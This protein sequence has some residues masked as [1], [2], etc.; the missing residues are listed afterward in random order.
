MFMRTKSKQEACFV[1]AG[2]LILL[3][4]HDQHPINIANTL[5]SI[6]TNF[7]SVAQIL[8]KSKKHMELSW[9]QLMCRPLNNFIAYFSA[10][11][12]ASLIKKRPDL[13]S[14]WRTDFDAFLNVMHCL[15]GCN[16]HLM[17]EEKLNGHFV[18]C[19]SSACCLTRT[20]KHL[21]T[22]H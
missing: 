22:W 21:S 20:N 16:E 13:T 2:N 19:F 6:S 15:P 7:L 8:T 18:L 12:V 10:Y 11:F 3:D 14:S 1:L 17:E 5:L 4:V 9:L